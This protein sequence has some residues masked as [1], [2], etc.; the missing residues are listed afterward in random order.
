[1]VWVGI[2]L[3]T[4]GAVFPWASTIK[5]GRGSDEHK[6]GPVYTH[7]IQTRPCSETKS[8]SWVNLVPVAIRLQNCQLRLKTLITHSLAI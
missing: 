7:N 6:T 3:L 4:R 5:T 1:M 8:L 2:S